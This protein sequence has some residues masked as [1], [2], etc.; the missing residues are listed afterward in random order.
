MVNDHA[1]AEDVTQE[2]FISALRRMRATERPIAFKPWIYEIA[3]ATRASTSTGARERG[4]E[5][6]YDVDGGLG[7][8][9]QRRLVAVDAAPDDA[10]RRRASS[11]TTCAARSATSPRAITGSSCC[12]SSRAAPTARSASGMGMSRPAV[13]STLFRARRRLTEEY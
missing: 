11:S 7:P 5:I 1:R 4:E 3:Q 13:E 2:V 8:P 10:G 6:S 12:A 9:D